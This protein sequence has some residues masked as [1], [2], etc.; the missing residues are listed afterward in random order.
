MNSCDKCGYKIRGDEGND[1]GIIYSLD[2]APAY[3]RNCGNAYPW[4]EEALKAAKEL[5]DEIDGLTSDEKELLTQ[6]CLATS[7]LTCLI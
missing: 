3:C 1:F 7:R 5:A 4:T 6:L 2:V